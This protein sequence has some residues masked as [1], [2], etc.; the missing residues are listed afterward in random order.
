VNRGCLPVF[1]RPTA[2]FEDDHEGQIADLPCSRPGSPN[3]EPS[4]LL[5]LGPSSGE[6][7]GHFAGNDDYGKTSFG[8]R[9][10]DGECLGLG[11]GHDQD[12][13]SLFEDW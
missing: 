4:W 3:D 12:R 9:S 11:P 13:Q 2:L 5:R 1:H 6:L 7:S 8:S 10:A